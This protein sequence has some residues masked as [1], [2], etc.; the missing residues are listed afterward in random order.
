[1][2]AALA[3]PEGGVTVTVGAIKVKACTPDIP[4]ASQPTTSAGANQPRRNTLKTNT[5]GY[6]L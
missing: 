4:I 3:R 5:F 6:E 2:N 1:V